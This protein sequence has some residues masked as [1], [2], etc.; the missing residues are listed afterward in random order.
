MPESKSGALP[1]GDSPAETAAVAIGGRETQQTPDPVAFTRTRRADAARAC[2]RRDRESARQSRRAPC[3]RA[4]ANAANTHAPDPVIRADGDAPSGIDRARDGG[5]LRSSDGLEIVA[6]ITLG[7]DIYF[8]RRR[9]RVSIPAHAKMLRSP[10]APR[11]REHEPQRR[12]RYR[13]QHFADAARDAR[14]RRRRRT[15]RRRRASRRSRQA[16]ARGKRA[17][18]AG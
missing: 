14:T 11:Q 18:T 6:A 1:L 8:R 12:Q 16:R 9:R 10:H 7:K 2:A 4:R 5:K 15:A 17:P 3:A 13:R